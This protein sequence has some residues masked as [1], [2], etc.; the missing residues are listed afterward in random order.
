MIKRIVVTF[1]ILLVLTTAVTAQFD[2]E[3]EVLFKLFNTEENKVEI[4]FDKSFLNQVSA[5]QL[6]GILKQ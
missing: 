3:K 6:I 5:N 2:K 4:L 1:I